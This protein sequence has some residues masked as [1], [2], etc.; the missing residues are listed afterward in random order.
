[1]DD[2]KICFLIPIYPDHYR[3]LTF[4]NILNNQHKFTIIFILTFINDKN[5]LINFLKNKILINSLFTN[6]NFIT[7]EENSHIAPYIHT[8][9]SKNLGIINIKKFYGLYYLINNKEYDKFDYIAAIDAEIEF[10]NVANIY[11]KFKT[12]CEKKLVI[13]GN[14]FIRKNIH[15][16]LDDIHDKTIEHFDDNAIKIINAE[17]NQG[18]YYFWY[19]DINIYD[20]KILPEF[21]KYIQFDDTSIHFS[22]FI[23]KMNFFSF[24]YII[25]Y[26]YCI[27][28]HNYKI[29]CMEKYDIKRHWSMEAAP[30]EIYMQ[31]K[32]K[33]NYTSNIVIGNCYYKNKDNFKK[34]NDEPIFIYSLNDGRYNNIYNREVDYLNN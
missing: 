17:T 4:L 3:Y 24:E 16:F 33:I 5:L 19:S 22:Q 28:F 18:K 32:H 7:L 27:V 31:V 1:M 9:N 23:K 15:N 21:F 11:E 10:I 12:Y 20:R 8:F 6:I 26:Y 30:Y 13:A 29:E 34:E 14:T 25:Y 2:D